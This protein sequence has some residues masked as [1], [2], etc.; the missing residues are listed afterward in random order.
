[1]K[2]NNTIGQSP[3]S[4][5]KK[6][7]RRESGLLV[8]LDAAE[9]TSSPIAKGNRI[10]EEK[11][12]E[13]G[14]RWVE[15]ESPLA[16]NNV[17]SDIAEEIFGEPVQVITSIR[18]KKGLKSATNTK[19]GGIKLKEIAIPLAEPTVPVMVDN[20]IGEHQEGVD[21]IVGHEGGIPAVDEL[22]VVP[23]EI[24]QSQSTPTVMID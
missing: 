6:N 4:G 1:V 21:G 16:S 5:R 23:E 3:R 12:P 9:A 10:R 11:T 19:V 13:K 17:Q 2:G 7:R 18:G 14:P 8:P 24:S 20:T 15:V 22:S